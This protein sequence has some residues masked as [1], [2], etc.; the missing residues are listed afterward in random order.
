M[1]NLF[2]IREL[3]LADTE[4]LP[5]FI[6]YCQDHG[7]DFII[8]AVKGPNGY[9]TCTLIGRPAELIAVLVEYCGGDEKVAADLVDMI[10]EV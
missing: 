7:V 4:G 8:K 2:R 10:E 5:A 3:D 6:H 1:T 9:P